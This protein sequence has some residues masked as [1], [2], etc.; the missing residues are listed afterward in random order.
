M[1]LLLLCALFG[2]ALSEVLLEEQFNDGDAWESSD[3]DDPAMTK[4]AGEDLL[5]VTK[6]A[7]KSMKD[8]QAPEDSSSPAEARNFVTNAIKSAIM[9]PIRAAIGGIRSKLKGA[10]AP[11][12]KYIGIAIAVVGALLVFF[13]VQKIFQC[14]KDCCSTL[15]Q[16]S[17]CCSNCYKCCCGFCEGVENCITCGGHERRKKEDKIAEK[18]ER[19]RKRQEMAEERRKKRDEAARPATSEQQRERTIRRQERD[20]VRRVQ[21]QR[22][23]H[24]Q[25]QQY[26]Y[27]QPQHYRQQQPQYNQQQPAHPIRFQP[28]SHYVQPPP[29]RR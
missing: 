8:A 24:L 18:E 14:C 1:K 19:F 5:A 6:E 21:F 25:Q 2:A 9:A 22:E 27:H 16:C 17:K 23:Q 4:K 7:Q 26:N 12:L 15:V 28:Q 13:L 3:T 10:I 29:Y 11:Y 20:K